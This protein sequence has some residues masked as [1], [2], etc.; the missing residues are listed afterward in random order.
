VR[1]G[2]EHL[3]VAGDDERDMIELACELPEPASRLGCQA[4]AIAP[5]RTEVEISEESFRAW[6]ELA[7]PDER[8]RAV[9]RWTARDADGRRR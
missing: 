7:T 6:L 3:S 4:R 9:A 1:S 8:Q 2:A 5:G